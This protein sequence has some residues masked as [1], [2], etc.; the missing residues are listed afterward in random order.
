MCLTFPVGEICKVAGWGSTHPNIAKQVYS[1]KLQEVDIPIRNLG[2]C[3]KN[4]F[5][6]L[7]KQKRG[8]IKKF[9]DIKKLD[10]A[11]IYDEMNICA[12]GH[13]KDSCTVRLKTTFPI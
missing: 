2:I 5:L 6:N 3:R 1:K 11:P 7:N 9:S 12:G 8:I 4:Y 13:S 10:Q